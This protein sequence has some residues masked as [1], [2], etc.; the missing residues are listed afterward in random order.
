[1]EAIYNQDGTISKVYDE[2]QHNHAGLLTVK[3][4]EQQTNDISVYRVNPMTGEVYA[5]PTCEPKYVK[6]VDNVLSEMSDEE[7]AGVDADIAASEQAMALQQIK[8]TLRD[9]DIAS[10]RSLREYVAA[11]ENAPQYVKD[12]EDRAKAERAKL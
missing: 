4:T 2:T 8:N 10:I 11:Q 6:N 3:L 5:T 7:K 9:I 12:H 1:M